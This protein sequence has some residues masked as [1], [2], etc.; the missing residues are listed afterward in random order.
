M[1][2]GDPP[3]PPPPPAGPGVAT[4]S[5][6]LLASAISVGIGKA[7][8]DS[9]DKLAKRLDDSMSALAASVNSSKETTPVAPPEPPNPPIPPVPP[10]PA[11]PIPPAP[12]ATLAGTPNDPL[13]PYGQTGPHGGNPF[14]PPATSNVS[15]GTSSILRY[16]PEIEA[17]ILQSVV[18]HELRPQHIYKLLASSNNKPIVPTSLFYTA[19]GFQVAEP[20]VTR[21]LPNFHVFQKALTLYFD[22]ISTHVRLTTGNVLTLAQV[23]HGSLFYLKQLNHYMTI[24]T[25]RTV[26]D[27]HMAFHARRLREMEEG[28]FSGWSR[29]DSE[30]VLEILQPSL[31]IFQTAASQASSAS[32]KARAPKSNSPKVEQTCHNFNEGKCTTP[33]HN[34]RIHKCSACNAE[35][36]GRSSCTTKSS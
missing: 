19:E 18:K 10:I 1:A 14:V 8:E 16:F 5:V 15:A 31:S 4:A 3:P 22:I 2:L 11:A 29:M 27:F 25:Y 35:G 7:F 24:Y 23:C 9:M 32:N 36:H 33:C 21:E 17:T 34:N 6:E 30:L 13:F 26:L 28:D 20:A 12:P